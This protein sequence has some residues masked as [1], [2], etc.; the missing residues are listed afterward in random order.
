MVINGHKNNYL[1]EIVYPC[2]DLIILELEPKQSEQTID[3]VDF[4]QQV[5]GIIFTTSNN[6]KD[7][8]ECYQYEANSYI[9]KPIDFTRFKHDIQTILDYWFAVTTLP[10][11]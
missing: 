4:Y 9:V 6:P 7:I 10:N 5:K 1:N 11:C 2:N 3:F 8:N